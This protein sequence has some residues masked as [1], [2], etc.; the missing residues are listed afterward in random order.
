MKNLAKFK[1]SWVIE[2]AVNE[3]YIAKQNLVLNELT[4][5]ITAGIT[6]ANCL[7]LDGKIMFCGNGGSAADSQH[8]AAELV[9]RF[10][11]ERKALAGLA[12]TTDTSV[13]TAAGNDLGFK[14]I[15]AR[16][17]EGLGYE[18][19]ILVCLSASGNSENILQA[20]KTAKEMGIYTIGLTGDSINKNL[21]HEQADLAIRATTTSTD[22][23]QETHIMIGHILIDL[24]ERMVN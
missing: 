17:V 21:L 1:Y 3:S 11:N 24:I 6:M 23:V 4:N 15:F 14:N 2:N 18:G 9:V 10:K 12:L 7:N 8:L 22:R 13:L 20:V 19:D 5:I 16:Q